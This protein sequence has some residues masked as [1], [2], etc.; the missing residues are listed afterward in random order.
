MARGYSTA[1]SEQSDALRRMGNEL[2]D[3]ARALEEKERKDAEVKKVAEE[4]AKAE[5]IV[6]SGKIPTKE[7]VDA[8]QK[9]VDEFYAA[10]KL[11]IR[12][13]QLDNYPRGSEKAKNIEYE[14]LV[15]KVRD[16]E[17]LRAA[18]EKLKKLADDAAYDKA[19][20][21]AEKIVKKGDNPGD[22]KTQDGP[23]V[24]KLSDK[25]S[26]I[27]LKALQAADKYFGAKDR[28]G[29]NAQKN[30]E[31][32]K[33]LIEKKANAIPLEVR[34]AIRGLSKH[35][36]GQDLVEA[37]YNAVRYRMEKGKIGTEDYEYSDW[38]DL[39]SEA[40]RDGV[41]TETG[42]VTHKG[43][44]YQWSRESAS[45]KIGYDPKKFAIQDKIV[46]STVGSR[47]SIGK[48]LFEGEEL[49]I[50]GG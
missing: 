48:V 15:K 22:Q 2:I 47:N 28:K 3:K 14:A 32:L 34:I 45:Y 11:A 43:I 24:A 35:N 27:G 25:M 39:R 13:V 50:E 10:N 46:I 12:N 20:K 30:K 42:N 38:S 36:V 8:A 16:L 17:E 41:Q 1:R 23:K 26:K 4:K 40:R 6:A 49:T 18:P 44:T 9:K 21:A 5:A 7:E 31:K 37:G 29:V 19:A 33:Q